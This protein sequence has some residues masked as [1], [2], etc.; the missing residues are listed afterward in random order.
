MICDVTRE[1]RIRDATQRALSV[2]S[3]PRAFGSRR[4]RG[5]DVLIPIFDLPQQERITDVQHHCETDKLGRA[6][7]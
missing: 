4:E 6:I 5:I 7:G 3:I 2:L 1:D